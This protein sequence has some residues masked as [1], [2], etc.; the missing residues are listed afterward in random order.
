MRRDLA[1]P[2]DPARLDAL[3][4]AGRPYATGY[5]VRTWRDR[6]PDDLLEGRAALGVAMSTDAPLGD[7]DWREEAW[8]VE[9]VRRRERDGVEQGRAH[10]AAGAVHAGSGRL[11]AFTEVAVAHETPELVR[12][13]ETL[14]EQAHRGHRLATLVKTA[15][16]RRLADELPEARAVITVNAG[17]NAPMVAI[18]QALGFRPDGELLNLQRVL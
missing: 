3:E 16:L 12:Q 6:C 13:W 1:L 17:T 11:V 15:V 14:V 18:N 9:R 10:L 4:E 7:L 2:A 8:D 5:E